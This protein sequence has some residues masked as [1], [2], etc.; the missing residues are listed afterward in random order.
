MDF[1]EDRKKFNSNQPIVKDFDKYIIK[2]EETLGFILSDEQKKAV[3]LI[4]DGANTILLIGYAGTG[5]ST[6]SKAILQLLE[7]VV[8]YDDIHCTALSGIAS[9]RIADTT[10]YKSSTIQSLLVKI[11]N[12]DKD[13]FDYKVILIDESSMVNSV[14]FYKLFSKIND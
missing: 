3:E 1:F 12:S 11:D 9:Q 4:N 7:E 6:S 10:G 5:K 8:S 13:Y 2:Q 14:T